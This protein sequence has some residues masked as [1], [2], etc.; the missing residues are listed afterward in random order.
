MVDIYQL[1]SVFKGT[2]PYNTSSPTKGMQLAH[3]LPIASGIA[4][5][6]GCPEGAVGGGEAAVL[7]VVVVPE[8]AVD[9]DDSFVFGEDEIG[10]AGELAVV[11]A[12]A[13]AFCKECLSD[14]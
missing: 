9:E 6:F 14:V 10:S 2:G 13:K 8:T 4:L 12:I 1:L 3:R 7:A 5:K 11:E